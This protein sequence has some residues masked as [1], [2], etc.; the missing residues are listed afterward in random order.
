MLVF[1]SIIAAVQM[2]NNYN[3]TGLASYS[4]TFSLKGAYFSLGN[5]D[6]KTKEQMYLQC[7]L[8]C[9]Q[10]LLLIFFYLMWRPSSYSKLQ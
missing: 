6:Y 3:G 5:N 9:A 2:Y 4:V 1:S 7:S 10:V 8:A